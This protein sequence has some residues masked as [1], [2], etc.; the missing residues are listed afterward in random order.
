MRQKIL[1]LIYFSIFLN[2]IQGQVILSP[3]KIE[4]YPQDQLLLLLPIKKMENYN[5]FVLLTLH[6]LHPKE[7]AQ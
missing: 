6:F 1:Y 7:N 5:L 3:S 4:V 2:I